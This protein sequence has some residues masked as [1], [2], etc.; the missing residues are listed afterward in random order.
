MSASSTLQVTLPADLERFV[1]EL[2]D[3]GTYGSPDEAVVEALRLLQDREQ[4]REEALAHVRRKLQEGVDAGDRGETLDGK[5]VMEEL[6]QRYAR[7][8][9]PAE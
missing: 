7:M 3:D 8:A 4:N 5:Q 2:V 9:R 1:A 6:R